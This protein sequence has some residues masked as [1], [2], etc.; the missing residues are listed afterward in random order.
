MVHYNNPDNKFRSK[1][2]RRVER[3]LDD[4]MI[5]YDSE[6]FFSPYTVDI[7][8]SEWH[9]CVEIDGPDHS[10]KKD[11]IRDE[12]LRKQYGLRILRINVKIWRSK[13]YIQDKILEFLGKYADS[14]QERKRTWQTQL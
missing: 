3:I 8:L 4:L 10:K 2:H 11:E 9:L 14:S 13:K 7:Y 5:N 1:P 6:I 12:W